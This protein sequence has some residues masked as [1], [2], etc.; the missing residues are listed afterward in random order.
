MQE[1]VFIQPTLNCLVNLTESPFFCCVLDKV[2]HVHFERV[3]FSSKT[4]D[5]VLVNTDFTKQPW[6]VDMVQNT[7]KDAIQE[8]LT[9]MDLPYTEGPMN[10]NWKQIMATIVE[11][12]RFYM[13]TE[14]DDVT[15]KEAGWEFL[16]MQEGEEGSGDDDGDESDFSIEEGEESSSEEDNDDSDASSFATESEEDSDFDGDEELEEGGMDWEEMEAEAKADDKKR[17]RE[18]QEQDGRASNKKRR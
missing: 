11:D 3:S 7:T 10:L 12:D 4:Y 1:M 13:D 17:A 8:W 14:E 16:R 15:P 9:D 5:I 6:R 2:D 18:T